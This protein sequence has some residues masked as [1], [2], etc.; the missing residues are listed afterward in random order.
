MRASGRRQSGKRQKEGA[1]ATLR[2]PCFTLEINGRPT[3]VL[4]AASLQAA[5][6]RV[7][8]DWF[9]EELAGMRSCGTALFRASDE[10]LVRP[11]RADE[12]AKLQLERALDALQGEDTKYAFAFLII[13]DT[14][15][16]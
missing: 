9:L 5:I 8:E 11:A 14:R 3:L 16:N 15:P 2:S 12:T 10:C 13:I 6:H 4:E 1:T 7:S